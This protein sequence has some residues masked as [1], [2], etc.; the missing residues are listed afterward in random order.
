MSLLQVRR[1]VYRVRRVRAKPVEQRVKE[2]WESPL[3][4]WEPQE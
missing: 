4:N 1:V 3:A 2:L